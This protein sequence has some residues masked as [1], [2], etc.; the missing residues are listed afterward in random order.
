MGHQNGDQQMLVPLLA[1]FS[2]AGM[3]IMCAVRG[4]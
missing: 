2:V 4:W 3:A 1:A